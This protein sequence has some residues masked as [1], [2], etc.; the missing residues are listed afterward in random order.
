MLFRSLISSLR[1]PP[2]DVI[3]IKTENNISPSVSYTG[4]MP[5]D[6]VRREGKSHHMLSLG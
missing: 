6:I 3:D 2:G 5:T 4:F 1:T